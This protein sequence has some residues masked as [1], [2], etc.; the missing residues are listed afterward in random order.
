MHHV[1][2]RIHWLSSVRPFKKTEKFADV[3]RCPAVLFD[4]RDRDLNNNE[5]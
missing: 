4:E 5:I 1:Y 3:N 2:V